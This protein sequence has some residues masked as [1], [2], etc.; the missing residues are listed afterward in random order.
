M[1]KLTDGENGTIATALAPVSGQRFIFDDHKAAPRGLALRVTTAGGKAFVLQYMFGGKQRRKTIGDWP[2]WSLNGARIEAARLMRLVNCGCDPMQSQKE[3][4]HT[5]N[6]SGDYIFVQTK[7]EKIL[8]MI[9]EHN[10]LIDAISLASKRRLELSL[11]IKEAL[12]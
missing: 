1:S 10:D 8:K 6:T 7:N 5:E 9:E 4:D 11:E 12:K 2:T 3:N